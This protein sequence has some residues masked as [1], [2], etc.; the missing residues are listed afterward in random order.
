MATVAVNGGD[1]NAALDA[2][3]EKV[4]REGILKQR[5]ANAYR[6][7]GNRKRRDGGKKR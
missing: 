1:I 6:G 3:K 5:N 7:K 4:K 2:F